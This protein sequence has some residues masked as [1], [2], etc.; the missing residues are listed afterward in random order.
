L[1]ADQVDPLDA[2]QRRQAEQGPQ[3]LLIIGVCHGH[4]SSQKNGVRKMKSK[5]FIS[6]P[7][8][9]CHSGEMATRESKEHKEIRFRCWGRFIHGRGASSKLIDRT[10]RIFLSATTTRIEGRTRRGQ[11]NVGQGNGKSPEREEG[12]PFRKWSG[13]RNTRNTKNPVLSRWFVFRGSKGIPEAKI[14]VSRR[15]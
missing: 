8:R 1:L 11:R 12:C 15:Y 6:P 14:L 10:I 5:S 7:A 4:N 2:A 9:H 3:M 13:P